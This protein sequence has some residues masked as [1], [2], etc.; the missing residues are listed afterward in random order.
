M[1]RSLIVALAVGLAMFIWGAISHMATPLGTMGFSELPEAAEPAFLTAL[2]TAVPKDGLYMVPGMHGNWQDEKVMAA[3]NEQLAKGPSGLFIVTKGGEEA[4]TPKQL[5][6][7][8]AADVLACLVAGFLLARSRLTSFVPRLAF[9]ALL[10]VA[11]WSSIELSYWNWY[12]FPL[13]YTLAQLV[14]Q[15]MGFVAAGIVLA[16]FGGRS[17]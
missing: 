6:I 17:V 15:V 16:K 5:G 13:E 7:E 14:D 12:H 4:M 3:H 9:V 10:G 8:F 1:L 2:E 11:A